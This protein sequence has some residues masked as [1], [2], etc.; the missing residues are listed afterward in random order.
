MLHAPVRSGPGQGQI[1]ATRYRYR[2]SHDRRYL[3]ISNECAALV[4]VATHTH[5]EFALFTLLISFTFLALFIVCCHFM[6]FIFQFDFDFDFSLLSS[7]HISHVS[8]RESSRISWP[9]GKSYV[10]FLFLFSY[11][12]CISFSYCSLAP[13]FLP[14]SAISLSLS[15]LFGLLDW[16][17]VAKWNTKRS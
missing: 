12:N 2:Y 3:K 9:I 6:K 8:S 11:F 4:V 17:S 16:E 1:Q 5:T 15:H 7:L 13:P 10:I 14:P